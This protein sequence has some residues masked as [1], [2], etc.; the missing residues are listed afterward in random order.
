MEENSKE[1]AIVKERLNNIGYFFKD[2]KKLLI[3]FI[4]GLILIFGLYIR[5]RNLDLL[6]DSTTG[7]YIPADPDAFAF[8]RYVKYIADHGSLMDVDTMRYYPWGYNNMIEFSLLSYMIAYS[9][10]FLHVF[11]PSITVELVDVTYP[12]FAFVLS[13]IFFFLFVRK[14][15]GWKV[16]MISTFFVTVMPGYLFR[17][18]TG[19]SDKEA[20]AL[21]FLF[22]ALCLYAYSIKEEEF[23]KSLGFA[24]GA[25]IST[26][27]MGLI[28]G[29]VSFLLLSIG[30]Y[31][32]VMV[33][34]EKADKK[35]VYGYCVWYISFMIL[36]LVTGRQDISGIIG[37][38]QSLVN[39]FAL[40]YS[41][42]YILVLKNKHF[43]K[44][45]EKIQNL[46]KIP[47]SLLAALIS[48]IVVILIT[49]PLWGYKFIYNKYLEVS[50]MLINPI[51]T[52]RWAVTVAEA[53][54]PHLVEWIS[55]VGW[56]VLLASIFGIA[57][58]VYKNLHKLKDEKRILISGMILI[59][60]LIIL[61]SRYSEGA[62]YLNGESAISEFI[63]LIGCLLLVLPFILG[64]FSNRE[65]YKES[66]L[67]INNLVVLLFIW[68]IV[69][70][71][72]SRS[73][74]R[75]LLMVIPVFAIFLS[76]ILVYIFEL[77]IKTKESWLKWSILILIFILI[78]NPVAVFGYKGIAIKFSQQTLAQAKS[79]GPGYNRQWQLGMEWVRDNTPKEAVFA[80]WWDYGYFVQGGGERATVTDGGNARGSLNHFMG[81]YV[82]T[83]VNDTEALQFLK[84]HNVSYLLMVSDEIGKY[85]AF[86]SIGAD[87]N[88]DR[89]SWINMF[90]R[91]DQQTIEKKEGVVNIYTGGTI[92]DEDLIYNG[93]YFPRGKSGIAAVSVPLMKDENSNMRI[94]QPIAIIINQEGKRA[95]IP[96]ECVYFN[97]KEMKFEKEG[98]KGCLVFIPAINSD[99]KSADNLK[100]LMYVSEKVKE[101]L[102]TRLYL[103][104][105]KNAYFEEVYND[106][107]GV[108]L[109]FYPF[110]RIVGPM[111]IYKINYPSDLQE[112]PIF[113]KDELPD[114]NVES[115]EGRFV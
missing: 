95:E 90:A 104:N 40:A 92:L 15:L 34:L 22:L 50:Q 57:F 115:L 32:L 8:M 37:G 33:I 42:I 16:A 14:I 1:E 41:L 38:F 94:M 61:F 99:Y 83:G 20:M 31:M 28:W 13:M 68:S 52:G 21:V 51:E 44:F 64:L 9:Y 114:P 5:T 79:L 29:G 112:N 80:H 23:L 4:L 62:K 89:Y 30:L 36:M 35:E 72:A 106:K 67:N 60:I 75:L 27:I 96:V 18:M 59:G 78:L 49:L 11:I 109:A 74:I 70:L 84:A 63:L 39:T 46:I 93:E 12:A 6:V 48:F 24:L 47:E 105:E 82:L 98:L 55:N 88:W 111:K 7:K 76:Y 107:Q 87:K 43:N 108:P 56:I 100:T 86:S 45:N 26:A 58:L 73:A 103:L 71:I 54:H 102:F 77:A 65:K 17:T 110:G 101:G 97:E 19:V 81:R 69:T 2:N 10:K 91:D 66:I 113:Y 3:I 85:P 25:G 53:H